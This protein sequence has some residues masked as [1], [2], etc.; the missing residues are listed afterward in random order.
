MGKES[1]SFR[2]LD[3]TPAFPG[4]LEVKSKGVEKTRLRIGRGFLFIYLTTTIWGNSFVNHPID[5][6]HCLAQ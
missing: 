4:S 3:R 1:G 5:R 2:C 6:F